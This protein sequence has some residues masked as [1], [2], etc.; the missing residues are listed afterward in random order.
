MLECKDFKIDEKYIKGK[1]FL[2]TGG[3]SGLGFYTAKFL[4]ERGGSV[5]I[6]CRSASKCDEAKKLIGKDENVHTLIIDLASFRSVRDA[7]SKVKK[8][9][10]KIDVLINNAGIM[11][12]PKREVTVDGLENQIQTNHFSH[13]LLTSLLLPLIKSNGG[14]RIINHSSM[15]SEFAKANFTFVDM[16][17]E[18]NYDPWVAYGNSKAANLLFTYELNTRLKAKGINDV[19]SV[20]LHP[21]YTGTNLQN[22]KYPGWEMIN[23]L[24]SMRLEDGSQSQIVAAV[25]PHVVPSM[26]TYIGPKYFVFGAPTVTKVS[27]NSRDKQQM[28]KLWTES[29]RLTGV[30]SFL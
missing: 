8:N 30:S 14:G 16:L 29:E 5:I 26:D 25:D 20:A 17:S 12:L 4:A 24:F 9:F 18:N 19:I 21:G 2:V 23:S 1:T 3:N 27:E 22:D 15:A 11:A 6:G 13:F 7:A 28:K 10:K